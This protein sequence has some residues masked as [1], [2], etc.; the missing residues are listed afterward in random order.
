MTLSELK[1]SLRASD[2]ALSE[3]SMY[4]R[5][6]KSMVKLGDGSSVALSKSTAGKLQNMERFHPELHRAVMR[7]KSTLIEALKVIL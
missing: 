2:E 7:N 3:Q 1:N 4:T 5:S 6:G